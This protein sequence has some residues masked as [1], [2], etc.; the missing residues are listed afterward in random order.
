VPAEIQRLADEA[1]AKL[2]QLDILINNA[3]ATWS[4][5]AEDHP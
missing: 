3:G 1:L 2:G 4:A 5:P